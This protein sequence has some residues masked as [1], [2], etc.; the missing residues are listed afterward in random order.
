MIAADTNLI[1]RHLTQDDANQA[2][3]VRD[4]FDAAEL[5]QE[6]IF[7]THIV[8]CETSWVLRAVYG[9]DKPQISLALQAVLDDGAFHIQD[10]PLVEEALTL[11]KR[12]AGQFS[13]H[14]LGIVVKHSGASTTYTFDKGVGKFPH[15]TLLK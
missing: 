4:L 2:K 3:K 6:P 11:Y 9:F 5:R 12:H 14:L 15:F 1:I 10:R 8:L 7:L 13:D